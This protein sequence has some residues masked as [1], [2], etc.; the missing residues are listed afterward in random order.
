MPLRVGWSFQLKAS[1]FVCLEKL[2]KPQLARHRP[3]LLIALFLKTGRGDD[4][5]HN[6]HQCGNLHSWSDTQELFLWQREWM[7]W[8]NVQSGKADV[9]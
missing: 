5:S 9:H 3:S 6:I 2:V 1:I 7:L 4:L 8:L